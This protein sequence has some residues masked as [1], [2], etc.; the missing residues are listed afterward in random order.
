MQFSLSA[1]VVT[2]SPLEDL[3]FQRGEEIVIIE[4]SEALY[5]YRA[6][7]SSGQEGLVP[8]TYLEVVSDEGK[9]PCNDESD[10]DYLTMKGATEEQHNIGQPNDPALLE[11]MR[12]HEKEKK[13]RLPAG[14]LVIGT[15][16]FS[17]ESPEDMPFKVYEEMSLLYPK[18]DLCWYYAQKT[19]YP[20]VKGTIPITHVR[21]VYMSDDD[22]EGDTI[23]NAPANP[24]HDR[25][26]DD[27]N[28]FFRQSGWFSHPGLP[29]G[30]VALQ[31]VIA[32]KAGL[33]FEKFMAMEQA[34]YLF[35]YRHGEKVYVGSASNLN[36]EICKHFE[37]FGKKRADITN[38]DDEL[39][40][41]T[42][43]SEWE[44]Q[45]W[46]PQSK[47]L[48][49]ECAKKVIELNALTS[50]ETQRGLTEKLS[51]SSMQS[52]DKLWNWFSPN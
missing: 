10:S 2:P 47:D 16:Q 45:V 4:P 31:H 15:C 25:L 1:D 40:H 24:A 50:K 38:I 41:H 18:Q 43:S 21:L 14:T 22:D 48:E 46:C 19:D 28:D 35:D 27:M 12:I 13:K 20:E 49:Y 8:R 39:C 6:K 37:N 11:M 9:E 23:Y 42:E 29:H 51:F 52:F 26:Y 17:G 33:S 44:I 32:K 5:W 30:K 36:D 34:V 3:S 7:N